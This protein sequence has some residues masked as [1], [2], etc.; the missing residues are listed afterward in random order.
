MCPSINLLQ[1][2]C[3]ICARRVSIKQHY[4]PVSQYERYTKEQSPTALPARKQSESWCP[5]SHSYKIVLHPPWADAA[6]FPQHLQ[7]SHVHRD[8][9]VNSIIYKTL[10]AHSMWLRFFAIFQHYWDPNLCRILRSQNLNA[11]WQVRQVLG[12]NEFGLSSDRGAKT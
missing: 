5:Q 4:I 11:V 8:V 2:V 9:E 1:T 10:C 12:R 7:T 3:G 6:F